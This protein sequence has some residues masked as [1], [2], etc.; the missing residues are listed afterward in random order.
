MQGFFGKPVDNLYAEPL[1]ARWIR[2]HVPDWKEAVVVSKNPS[3]TKRVTSLADALKLNFAIVATDRRRSPMND[4]VIIDAS[5]IFGSAAEETEDGVGIPREGEVAAQIYRSPLLEEPISPRREDHRARNQE[6]ANPIPPSPL[7]HRHLD[8]LP[9]SSPLAQSMRAESESPPTSRTRRQRSMT[10]P[11]S[12][13]TPDPDESVEEYTDE[14]AREVITSRLIQGHVVDDDFPS[15][16]LSTVSGSVATLPGDQIGPPHYEDRD[17]MMSSFMSTVSSHAQDHT[18]GG[19]YDT[20]ATSD[21]DEEEGFKHPE[22]EQTITLIGN[23][24]NR[25]VFIID[26]MIDTSGS[27]IA[28]AETVV[29]RGDAKKVYCIATHGIFSDE[30]LDDME[31][32]QCIDYIMVSN[33]F[34]I[35]PEKV[36]AK[37]KL[38]V[39]D[40]SSL[41]AEA[42]RRN[43]Y[44]ESLSSLYHHFQD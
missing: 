11:V 1:I 14:R 43:H 22:V 2:N 12:R 21:E 16:V 32:C 10:A 13:R 31:A 6:Q 28:A 15:P 25:T 36:Q 5:G 42:I 8:R 33:T 35:A 3:G 24:R 37:K 44:G 30:S 7:A 34:P 26:D 38:V 9:G 23:V 41:L 20:G 17:H 19:T 27:W 39:L 4:S 40:L 18:F 29:K